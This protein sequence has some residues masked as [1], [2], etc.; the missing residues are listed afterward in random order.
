LDC[1]REQPLDISSLRFV[2]TLSALL[3]LLAPYG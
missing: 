3:A 1:S 2:T